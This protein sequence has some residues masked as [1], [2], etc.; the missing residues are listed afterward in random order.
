MLVLLED[1]YLI[2]RKAD[3]RSIDRPSALPCGNCGSATTIVTVRLEL[4]LHVACPHCGVVSAVAKPDTFA[5]PLGT[6]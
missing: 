3:R 2:R 5:V 1:N 6:A 4:V